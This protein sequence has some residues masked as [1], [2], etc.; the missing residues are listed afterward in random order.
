MVNR[1]VEFVKEYVEIERE[2]GNDMTYGCAISLAGP[3]YRKLYNLPEPKKKPKKKPKKDVNRWVKHVRKYAKDNNVSY[4]CAIKDARATYIK[5]GG[6]PKP[7]PK[8]K[9]KPT[10]K[11]KEESNLLKKERVRREKSS[12]KHNEFM[13]KYE[14][15]KITKKDVDKAEEALNKV[16]KKIG[17][18]SER[19]F[20]DEYISA[21]E[22]VKVLRSL[23]KKPK[24]VVKGET[25]PTVKDGP[26]SQEEAR[27]FLEKEIPRLWKTRENDE[28][29]FKYTNMLRHMKGEKRITSF[30]F[31]KNP[32]EPPKPDSRT[33][34][35]PKI[36]HID[37]NPYPYERYLKS[38]KFAPSDIAKKIYDKAFGSYTPEASQEL[39]KKVLKN[40]KLTTWFKRWMDEYCKKHFKTIGG[41]HIWGDEMFAM[42]FKNVMDNY[43]KND[44]D[45]YYVNVYR[46][47]LKLVN[48]ILTVLNKRWDNTPIKSLFMNR[49][50][51]GSR[52]RT[53]KKEYRIGLE[54]LFANSSKEALTDS[55]GKEALRRPEP[56]P[57]A[58]PK[59]K[60]NKVVY[61][62][63]KELSPLEKWKQ[64]NIIDKKIT[65]E[66][67]KKQGA[68]VDKR[69]KTFDKDVR[70][71][72]NR[73][74]WEREMDKLILLK[75]E[76]EKQNP[77]EKPTVKP[78]AEPKQKTY[79]SRH[80][81]QT[82]L[83]IYSKF[84]YLYPIYGK[85]ENYISKI[86][87]THEKED[88]KKYGTNKIKLKHIKN[89]YGRIRRDL[90]M[91]IYYYFG[92][93]NADAPEIEKEG[94]VNKSLKWNLKNFRPLNYYINREYGDVSRV[95][96]VNV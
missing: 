36:E 8:A 19:V 83:N 55:S 38:M 72:R 85:M 69:K 43:P 86:L 42:V 47:T 87:N 53:L 17:E 9:P 90:K 30:K 93:S 67:I 51:A 81:F 78:K 10:V 74:N 20:N 76:Y 49:A 92:G 48:Y 60:P 14:N 61:V 44:D 13:K 32:V 95:S 94:D 75:E 63:V 40:P 16:V 62:S 80:S 12:K 33:F 57:V 15:K 77:E 71:K 6:K 1:W 79:K 28:Q 22:N 52:L 23:Y 96:Y 46:T 73:R 58:K 82:D 34:K 11:A 29:L 70:N 66:A 89:N 54:N 41:C 4:G 88:I 56:K 64:K 3:A 7:K 50:E 31:F 65:M 39:Y 37:Y 21:I 18:N 26:V 68:T 45:L 59:A 5:V 27:K 2:K 84:A 25:K 35:E 91:D 24:P